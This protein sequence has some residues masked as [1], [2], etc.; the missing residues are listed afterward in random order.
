[1]HALTQNLLM[2]SFNKYLFSTS[3]LPGNILGPWESVVNKTEGKK[4]KISALMGLY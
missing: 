4:K 1:M 2:H 3:F